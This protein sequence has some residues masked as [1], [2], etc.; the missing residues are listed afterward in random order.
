MNAKNGAEPVRVENAF[1]AII[2]TAQFNRVS[3]LLQSRAPKVINPRR[4]VSPFL[5]SGLV[6]CRTCRRALTGQSSKYAQFTYYVCQTL[7]K[8]GK[9]SCDAPR[10]NARRFEELVVERIWSNFLTVASIP[11]LVEAVDEEIDR[12][13]AEHRKRLQ[14]IESEIQDVKNQLDR[15]WRY[16]ATRDD[17]DVAMT[18]ARMAEYRDRQERL[19]DAAANAREAVAQHRSDMGDAGEIAEY[20]RQMDDFLDQSELAERRAF[21]ESFVKE[22]V[23]MPGAALLRYTMPLPDDS[24]MPR[25]SAEKL[26][27]DGSALSSMAVDA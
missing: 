23:V 10:V 6:K 13:G 27:L 9:G 2:S 15:I 17:I 7:M 8:Q 18:S 16:I 24:P 25:R 20:A 1:P 3:K 12:M 21:I 5:L 11:N 4:A 26:A 14:T 22:V 19:E